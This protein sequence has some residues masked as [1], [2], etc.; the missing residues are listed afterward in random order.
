MKKYLLLVMTLL[1]GCTFH[2][3][4]NPHP[5]RTARIVTTNYTPYSTLF[6]DSYYRSFANRSYYN[7]YPRYLVV[8][9][10]TT[11]PRIE[12][13]EPVQRRAVPRR[14]N[15]EQ[16]V[17]PEQVRPRNNQPPRRRNNG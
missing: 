13:K 1:A 14:Q 15:N 8:P 3:Y 17:R 9:R 6:W 10:T 12:Y 16:Q 5:V 7:R 11:S 2:V 4:E